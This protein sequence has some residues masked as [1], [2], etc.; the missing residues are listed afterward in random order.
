MGTSP[1]WAIGQHL[2]VRIRTA[3]AQGSKALAAELRKT[4]FIGFQL[5]IDS[6][7]SRCS[8]G[9]AAA[10]WC[11]PKGVKGASEASVPRWAIEAGTTYTPAT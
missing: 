5:P 2:E 7:F 3:K 1:L 9:S 6:F 4:E 8:T 10:D 11:G